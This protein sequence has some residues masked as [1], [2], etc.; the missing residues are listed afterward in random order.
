MKDDREALIK[1][2]RLAASQWLYTFLVLIVPCW[3]FGW[4][5]KGIQDA[6][7]S[8]FFYAF[9][10]SVIGAVLSAIAMIWGW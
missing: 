10:I 7:M 5:F 8:I 4:L 1:A 9:L 6:I 2:V 3:F